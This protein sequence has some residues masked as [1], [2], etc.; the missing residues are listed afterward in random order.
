[1]STSIPP[2]VGP[3]RVALLGCGRISRNHLDAIA[4]VGEMQLVS[5]ADTSTKRAQ[6][7]GAAYG[8]P[9]FAFNKQ[10]SLSLSLAAA[11]NA[12]ISCRYSRAVRSFDVASFG[13]RQD[14]VTNTAPPALALPRLS[15]EA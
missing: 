6:E 12:A 2:I 10:M 1:M 7:V 3:I 9:V 11:G 13:E 15:I 4:K 5:V 14:S 8:V